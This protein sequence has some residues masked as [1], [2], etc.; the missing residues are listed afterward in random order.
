M[1]E[2]NK[3]SLVK[4]IVIGILVLLVA[5]YGYSWYKG[6]PLIQFP[7]NAEAPQVSGTYN[8]E[9]LSPEMKAAKDAQDRVIIK[10]ILSGLVQNLPQEE[11]ILQEI[12]DVVPMKKEQP[13]FANALNGDKLV[14]FKSTERAILF[15]PSEN[16]IVNDGKLVF[17]KK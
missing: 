6:V 8:Y 5:Y 14:I 17:I 7:T 13:F 10:S 2:I 1:Q 3:Q 16:R 12:V 11:F 4:K 15:R 9:E